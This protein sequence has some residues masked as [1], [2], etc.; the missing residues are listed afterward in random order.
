MAWTA[1]DLFLRVW[2]TLLR[3]PFALLFALAVIPGAWA[4]PVELAFARFIPD[5]APA[6]G[7]ERSEPAFALSFAAVVWDAIWAAGGFRIAIDVARG[8]AVR[9]RHLIE[10]LAYTP[11]IVCTALPLL[12]L[13]II[14]LLPLEDDPNAASL[15][16]GSVFVLTL[17]L[18]TR[19][20]LWA[21]FLL[22]AGS[23]ISAGLS[24]SW[25]A[26]RYRTLPMLVLAGLL[27]APIL[28]VAI[29]EIALT[30]KAYASIG[31]ANLF[32]TLA[33]AHLYTLAHDR[34]ERSL[35]QA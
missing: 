35:I 16:F 31:L 8:R 17:V 15:A 10:G 28:P 22:D 20:A 30:G 5:G 7:P 14:V 9:L 2:R 11:W 12:P 34:P 33:I 25:E 3:R 21:P 4:V 18:V 32:Y 1:P 27:V 23:S 6:F 29:L 13:E 19:S 26:T 24:A